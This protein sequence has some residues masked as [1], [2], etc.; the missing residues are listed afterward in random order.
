MTARGVEKGEVHRSCAIASDEHSHQRYDEEPVWLIHKAQ[1]RDDC[2]ECQCP[3]RHAPNTALERKVQSAQTIDG[4]EFGIETN[5]GL[6][7]RSADRVQGENGDTEG[8]RHDAERRR[9]DELGEQANTEQRSERGR[10]LPSGHP[11]DLRHVTRF[12]WPLRD[13]RGRVRDD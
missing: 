9:R 4:G 11:A 10:D 13:Q 7:E 6:R 8:E 3:D 5:R 1:R 12:H 2:H